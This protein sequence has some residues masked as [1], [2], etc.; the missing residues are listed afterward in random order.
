MKA[1]EAR[2]FDN[3]FGD[4]GDVST[5]SKLFQSLEESVVGAKVEFDLS[6]KGSLE[7]EF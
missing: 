5:D 3:K 4:D 2:I 6:K 7:A 1:G